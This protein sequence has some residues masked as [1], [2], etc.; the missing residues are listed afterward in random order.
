MKH[1]DSIR[2]FNRQDGTSLYPGSSG[3][4]YI[5]RVKDFNVWDV[6]EFWP[7]N[8]TF[9]F[10]PA[11]VQ[12]WFGKIDANNKNIYEGNLMVMEIS[13]QGK[14]L[15]HTVWKNAEYFDGESFKQI[16]KTEKLERCCE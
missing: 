16:Q 13:T 4:F 2:I 14:I 8:N 10:V 3:R 11:V 15:Q 7:T 1:I 9:S 6:N 12:H 5:H